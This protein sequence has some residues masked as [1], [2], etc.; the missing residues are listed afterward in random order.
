MK[1]IKIS[2]IQ[3]GDLLFLH[4]D[5]W[6]AKQI[7]ES[8]RDKGNEHWYLNHVGV[9]IW[10]STI[11][12]VGEEDYPGRFD[13]SVFKSQYIDLN[14]DVY[15]GRFNKELTGELKLKLQL[16]FLTEASENRLTNYG[17]LDILAFK[18]NS[19]I[20]KWFKKDVWIGRKENKRD[21]YTC[22]QRT[23]RFIQDYYGLL[24]DENYLKY[25]PADLA[26][27]NFIEI[28]RISFS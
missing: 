19:L 25:T 6:L 3:T 1:R 2:E 5:S 24:K 18:V 27:E 11:L 20:F 13:L 26:D 22:S 10:E 8:Q 21:R 14:K 4:G 15:L 16:E 23:A 9:F 12:C 7:Q 28:C 17:Y